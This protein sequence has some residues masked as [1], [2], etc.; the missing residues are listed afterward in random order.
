MARL[1]Y[2]MISSLDGYVADHHGGFDWAEPS[3]DEHE[4]FNEISRGIGTYLFGRRMHE[5]MSAW[6]TMPDDPALP[7]YLREFAH[8]WRDTD[9]IVFSSTLSAP[10]TSRTT[11]IHAFDADAVRARKAHDQRDLAIAGPTLAAHALRAGLVDELQV[12]LIPVVVGGGLRLLPEGVH[13]ELHLLEQRTFPSG[14]V[15]LRY[16]V[17]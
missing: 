16:R 7:G 11:L 8:L 1:I 5:V 2:S 12:M 17:G 13:L 3:R 15:F 9:K 6:E 10:G 4:F 14:A